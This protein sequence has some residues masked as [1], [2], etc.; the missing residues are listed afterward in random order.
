M[1]SDYQ[2][3]SF[4]AKLESSQLSSNRDFMPRM[5]C[6]LEY[7]LRL[8]Q[9]ISVFQEEPI[10]SSVFRKQTSSWHHALALVVVQAKGPAGCDSGKPEP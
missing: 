3:P 8:V 6:Q 7:F 4:V 2:K 9:E 10:G 1:A 5:C